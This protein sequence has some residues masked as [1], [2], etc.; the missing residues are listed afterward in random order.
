MLRT[1]RLVPVV[2]ILAL[3]VAGC[4]SKTTEEKV[5]NYLQSASEK[6]E[7]G[8]IEAAVIELKNALQL[9]PENATARQRLGGLYL[10]QRRWEPAAKELRRAREFGVEGPAL[11]RDLAH[12]LRGANQPKD[13]L[14]LVPAP[15]SDD[16]FDSEI[17]R[18]LYGLR[19]QALFLTEASDAARHLAQRVLENGES[20]EAR[21]AMAEM[22]ANDRAYA[23]AMVHAEKALGLRPDS[24]RAQG[25]KADSLRATGQIDRALDI[26][27]AAREARWR[28]L[29]VDLTLVQTALQANEFELAWSVVNDLASMAPKDPRVKYFQALENMAKENY[30]EARKLAESAAGQAPD[31]MPAAYVAGA[32]NL[33]LENYEVAREHL[34]RVAGSESEF[35]LARVFLAKAWQGLDNPKR[36]EDLVPGIT[37]I[38]AAS[39]GSPSDRQV[40]AAV[41]AD[42]N[43][44][45]E[46][47]TEDTPAARRDAVRAIVEDL[48]AE[49]F[50]AA[51]TKARDL[52]EAMPDSA[53]PLQLQAVALLRQG[54]NSEA[55]ARM[56]A[57]REIAPD[58]PNVLTNLARIH[59]IEER[60]DA[61]LNV[62]EPAM[63]RMPANAALKIEAARTYQAKGNGDKV[64]AL[65]KAAVEAD[66]ASLDARKFLARFRL[67]QDDPEAALALI[68]EA[69]RD[70]RKAAALLEI[71][72]RAYRRLG[73][74]EAAVEAFRALT[75]AAPDRA[76]AHVWLGRALLDQ[77]AANA[78]VAPLEKARELAGGEARV[79]LALSEAYRK[80]DDAKSAADVAES[81]L[82]GNPDNAALHLAAARARDRLGDRAAVQD[83]LKAALD[84]EPGS[85]AARTYLARLHLQQGDAA[86]AL[87]VVGAAPED[88]AQAPSLLEAKGRAQRRLERHEAAI[89]S[90]EALIDA[91]PKQAGGY[92]LAG[93]TYLAADTPAKAMEILERGRETASQG[94]RVAFQLA[95][96]LI[97]FDEGQ[98]VKRVIDD[99]AQA[100]PDRAA[101]HDL[102]AEYLLNVEGDPKAATDALRQAYEQ[103]RT[104]GRLLNLARLEVRRGK[105]EE[106]MSRLR[107]WRR[108]D[109]TASL[110][111]TEVLA[112]LELQQ[113]NHEAASSLYRELS[114]RAPDNAAYR[115]NL[116]WTL[117]EQGRYAPALKHAR[118]AIELAPDSPNVRDTLG[119]VLLASGESDAAVGHLAKAH[120]AAS[121]RVDIALH[122]AEAL[123]ADGQ[124]DKA[125]PI[126]TDL[127]DRDLSDSQRKDL[128]RLKAKADE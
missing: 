63:A 84:S 17:Q 78:A 45:V 94:D 54:K 67:L 33:Q 73:K 32:A 51:L 71:E 15:D 47:A 86:R 62:L 93:E 24:I 38:A 34:S 6:A 31:F 66:P 22:L 91:V 79:A 85:V 19:A 74:T 89:R 46:G 68:R 48:N 98:R 16:A 97:R 5:R 72:G 8:K 125:R 95:R 2:L 105:T 1:L 37:A 36:A 99:L 55:L 120:E 92:I 88:R 102:R 80:S 23:E 107:D 64:A 119:V 44:T 90:F 59:R 116:A 13:V 123:I 60:Y 83:H 112:Q 20:F 109:G 77:G 50:D 52:E 49:R 124:A 96:A 81:A 29:T 42:E 126:L 43:V 9:K 100:Y 11:R 53:V 104:E 121:S 108:S 10:Q 117:S 103:E 76:Q 12:A 28:P 127:A 56:E 115:N 27:T 25:I 75:D 35:P 40:A 70:Q 114:R 101:V 110:R 65:L 4:D 122:Y 69:P 57:A 128:A 30:E 18:D 87:E 58:S 82:S 106:A 21:L 3:G 118:K 61:A 14:D 39:E 113:G 41:P 26:L 7:S 111:V